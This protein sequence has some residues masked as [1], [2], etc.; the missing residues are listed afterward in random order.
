MDSAETILNTRG[1]LRLAVLA[2]VDEELT[3]KLTPIEGGPLDGIQVVSKGEI[4]Q[5]IADVK[6]RPLPPIDASSAEVKTPADVYVDAI[7]PECDL[8]TRVLVVISAVLETTRE[9]GSTIKL[10]AKAKGKT[11]VHHQLSLDAAA[12]DQQDFGLEDI[13]RPG[14]QLTDDDEDED[15][16]LGPGGNPDPPTG[17]PEVDAGNGRE[18]P[19]D[20]VETT[21]RDAVHSI[22]GA[23]PSVEVCNEPVNHPDTS[24]EA[25][26][27]LRKGHDG[28][29]DPMGLPF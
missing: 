15:E 22:A 3:G 1:A 13:V 21:D 28:D 27:G 11:H 5:A 19:D 8:P 9:A 17:F 16:D 2:A 24:A 14:D 4:G 29:H 18:E 25:K 10:K 20:D 23:K 12:G 26:C 7:C 6:A